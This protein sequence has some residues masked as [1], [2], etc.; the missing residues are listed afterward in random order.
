MSNIM[1]P[2]CG[3]PINQRGFFGQGK[4]FCA[5]CGWNLQRAENTLQEKS[6]VPLFIFVA[7]AILA[8]GLFWFT[9]NARGGMHPAPAFAFLAIFALAGGLPLWSYFST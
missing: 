6:R 5:H 8:I 2:L 1:C 7:F 3:S 9:S 4:P